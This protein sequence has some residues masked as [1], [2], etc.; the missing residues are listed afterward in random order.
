MGSSLFTDWAF[1]FTHLLAAE[2]LLVVRPYLIM[3]P[4]IKPV[5]FRVIPSGRHEPYLIS[6][7][8]KGHGLQAIQWDVVSGDPDPRTSARAAA[9]LPM[10]C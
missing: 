1:T 3:D 5:V 6:A 9:G 2:V 4:N 8:L 10:S 7:V